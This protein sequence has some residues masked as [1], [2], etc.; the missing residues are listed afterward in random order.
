MITVLFNYCHMQSLKVNLD[1]SKIFVFHNEP[2]ISKNLKWNYDEDSLVTVDSY[3]YLLTYNLSFRKH[4]K[5]KL[6]TAK[7]AIAFIWSKY[8]NSSNISNVN[9]LKNF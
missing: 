3:K 1:K 2:R 6:V 4:L 8:I 7:M 5:N 9:K